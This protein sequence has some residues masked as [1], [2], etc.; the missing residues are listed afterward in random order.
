[1]KSANDFRPWGVEMIES[2]G[3]YREEAFLEQLIGGP[4]YSNQ[5]TMPRL[6][7]P[8][9]QD[10]MR[11]FLPT[12]LPLARTKEEEAKLKEAC[13]NFPEQAQE[14]QQRLLE[15]RNGDF[16]DSSWLQLWWNQVRSFV[17]GLDGTLL[18][19][20]THCT[21]LLFFLLDVLLASP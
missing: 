18:R 11:R 10:T 14:L 2:H 12:A 17:D 16:R 1:M 5:A 15:R 8:S 6:P 13:Q 7:I 4:L 21:S 9:I 19:M 20:L 3:D